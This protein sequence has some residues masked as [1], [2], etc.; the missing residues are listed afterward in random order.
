MS[1]GWGGR[2]TP[3]GVLLWMAASRDPTRAPWKIRPASL[4]WR[5]LIAGMIVGKATALMIRMIKITIRSSISVNPPRTHGFSGRN[6]LDP[7]RDH[8]A[9]PP[10]PTVD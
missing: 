8:G 7:I 3:L 1:G 5:W 10:I 6:R 2:R 9:E 4:T